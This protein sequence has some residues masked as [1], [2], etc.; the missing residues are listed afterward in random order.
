MSDLLDVDSS[1]KT[2][3][4]TVVALQP[5]S[6]LFV[7]DAVGRHRWMVADLLRYQGCLAEFVFPFA[8]KQFTK[9]WIERLLF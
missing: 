5:D 9:E 2:R 4:L 3:F 1:T 6:M 7:G 8:Q